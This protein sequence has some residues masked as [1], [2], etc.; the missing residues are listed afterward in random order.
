M[1]VGNI[2]TGASRDREKIVILRGHDH[3][4]L[5]Y[6]HEEVKYKAVDSDVL[7]EKWGNEQLIL[8]LTVFGQ[9]E[10]LKDTFDG[11]SFLR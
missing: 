11:L 1:A 8:V 10:D 5:K 9:E 2:F 6:L 7:Y 4:H 3:K